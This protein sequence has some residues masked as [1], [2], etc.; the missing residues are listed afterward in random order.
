MEHQEPQQCSH[1]VCL[2]TRSLLL[3]YETVTLKNSTVR[4]RDS[5]ISATSTF[6]SPLLPPPPLLS[7]PLSPPLSTS[8]PPPPPPPPLQ[9]DQIPALVTV[10]LELQG[11]EVQFSP[12][13]S[14]HS[15]LPSVPELV[16]RWMDSYTRVARLA[17]RCGVHV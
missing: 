8:P 2:Y 17:R 16:Q 12:P 15:A 5:T 13:L 14:S 10:Q 11:G 3:W 6:P 1:L 7:P 4:I 9:G